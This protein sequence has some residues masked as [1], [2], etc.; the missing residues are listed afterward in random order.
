MLLLL[1]RFL[2]FKSCYSIFIFI[3]VSSWW[4]SGDRA[5]RFSRILHTLFH[6]L[7]AEI[8]LS[9]YGRLDQPPG[10]FVFLD[11]P[12]LSS[13][14]GCS[15]K[16]PTLGTLDTFL[17]MLTSRI[18]WPIKKMHVPFNSDARE[19]LISRKKSELFGSK[20]R[21]EFYYLGFGYYRAQAPA[22][23]IQKSGFMFCFVPLQF[24]S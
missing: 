19:I 6:C 23:S 16:T 7:Y 20:W 11:M 4:N 9:T 14:S 15:G 13:I 3:L 18:F 12:G 10:L 17:T 2:C 22:G 1:R 5:Y 21:A 24:L 8:Q